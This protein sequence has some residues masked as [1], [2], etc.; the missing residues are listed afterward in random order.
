MSTFVI[1]TFKTAILL[2]LVL[3]L[4]TGIIYPAI[5]TLIAQ[6]FFSSSANGSLIMLNNTIVGSSL[7]GQPFSDNH[8]FWGRPSATPDFPYNA[9][10][11]SGA[12]LALSNLTYQTIIDNRIALLKSADTDNQQP[13]PAEL[14][15]SSAS[16][17]DPDISPIAAYYQ[18]SRIAKARQVNPDLIIQLINRNIIPRTF[19][20]L[21]EPRVNVLTLNLALDS[22]NLTPE[23]H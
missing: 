19:F 10:Y 23:T 14:I 16:G 11:S 6:T 1:R 2:F 20:I 9:A 4:L 12:N 5:V 3:T 21:G 18:A 8:Y 7:I 22:M 13:I 15:M 17:L